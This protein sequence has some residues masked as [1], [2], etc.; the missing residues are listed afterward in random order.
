MPYFWLSCLLAA[1]FSGLLVCLASGLFDCESAVCRDCRFAA[2]L[3]PCLSPHLGFFCPFLLVCAAGLRFSA[4][5]RLSLARSPARG[6]FCPYGLLLAFWP[7]VSLDPLA[8]M[9]LLSSRILG[10]QEFRRACFGDSTLPPRHISVYESWSPIVRPLTSVSRCIPRNW[11][12]PEFSLFRRLFYVLSV[13]IGV[14]SSYRVTASLFV[15]CC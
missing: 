3:V 6:L 7:G 11:V 8:G 9:V 1:W 2:W 4:G 14:L 13:S 12:A 5:F 10:N 15:L